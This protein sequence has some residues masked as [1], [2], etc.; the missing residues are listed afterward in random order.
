MHLFQSWH[1]TCH[2]RKFAGVFLQWKFP[3]IHITIIDVDN[4]SCV[5]SCPDMIK[6]Q[7]EHCQ[8]KESFWEKTDFI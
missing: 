5:F 1:L 6:G 4:Y 7:A 8:V 3:S 2:S